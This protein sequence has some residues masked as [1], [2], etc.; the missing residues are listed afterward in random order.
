MMMQP[1]NGMGMPYN[2]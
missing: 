2:Q 1:N